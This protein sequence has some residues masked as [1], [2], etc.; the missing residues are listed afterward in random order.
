MGNEVQW[1]ESNVLGKCVL[2][3]HHFFNSWLRRHNVQDNIRKSVQRFLRFRR[4]SHV[5]QSLT[6]N[7]CYHQNR[8]TLQ[9]QPTFT[10]RQTTRPC[11]LPYFSKFSSVNSS[12]IPSG[13]SE[14]I[15]PNLRRT[16]SKI[17]LEN[18][19]KFVLNFPAIKA[20]VGNFTEF[21]ISDLIEFLKIEFSLVNSE[22]MQQNSAKLKKIIFRRKHVRKIQRILDLNFLN[23]FENSRILRNFFGILC[24]ILGDWQHSNRIGCEIFGNLPASR[25]PRRRSGSR[26]L[27]QQ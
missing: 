20:A 13:F 4:L 18:R 16:F 15:I 10:R 23:F 7:D 24:I 1:S 12:R 8:L 22:E 3:D 19:M 11:E 27:A 9:R 25:S 14:I 17:K 6:A 2:L 5:C 21:S 26:L